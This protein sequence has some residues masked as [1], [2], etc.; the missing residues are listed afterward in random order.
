[1]SV[2][3]LLVATAASAWTGW[4]LVRA[5]WPERAGRDIG[6]VLVRGSL[7][8]GLGWAGGGV[9]YCLWRMMYPQHG[10]VYRL[11]DCV[12]IPAIAWWVGWRGS[13]MEPPRAT[14]ER[15]RWGLPAYTVGLVFVTAGMVV[16]A[17][18]VVAGWA[19]RE[20]LGIW[21][22]WA[23]WNLKARFLYRGGADW[24][25]V[26]SME[27]WFSH[28]D[29]PL[30]LPATIARLWTYLG[31]ETTLV[32]QVTSI[33]YTGLVM[34]LLFG[35]VAWLRGVESACYAV[36]LLVS[37]AAFL[38]Y[39]GG[40]VADVPMSLYVLG[41]MVAIA[42][43][44]R[45]EQGR[46]KLMVLAGVLAGCAA[47]LK[48]EGMVICLALLVATF[49]GRKKG[50]G[51][52]LV[53]AGMLPGV[54]LVA[55]Q[56]TLFAGASYLVADQPSAAEVLHKLFDLSRHRTIL[57]FLWECN[58]GF[59]GWWP[60]AEWR[61]ALPVPNHAGLI[62]AIALVVVCGVRRGGRDGFAV[63]VGCVAVALTV[64]AYYVTLLAMPYDLAELVKSIP[65][66]QLHV[67]PMLI[68]MLL[69]MPRDQSA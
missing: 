53:A 34:T 7:A 37:S 46:G 41:A 39:G 8:M 58:F 15:A 9:H 44:G 18:V 60:I 65:R 17:L 23:I 30:L 68:F 29:Y 19:W 64:A 27:I 11:A 4:W 24:T 54:L 59:R 25:G 55:G 38:Y 45:A 16:G 47:M 10:W 2:A 51:V 26:F 13:Q 50:R 62:L 32:P 20:P 61:L 33:G 67:W 35:A 22:G 28:P 43:A 21:D 12:A 42:A 48:N 40:Q 63:V 3:W 14:N 52:L 31:Q 49:V 69:L 1:M 56:K 6:T 36:L 57:G 5:F 66:L